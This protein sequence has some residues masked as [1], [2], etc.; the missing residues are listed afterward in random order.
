METLYG[1]IREDATVL[2]D[3]G[4]IHN[5]PVRG[6]D[7][8]GYPEILIDAKDIGGDD[9]FYRQSIKPFV[10]MRVTFGRVEKGYQ[11][12]NYKVIK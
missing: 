5:L 12:F 6:T 10:G 11:G 9:D 1:I 8:D 3:D 4:T 2:A 7:K